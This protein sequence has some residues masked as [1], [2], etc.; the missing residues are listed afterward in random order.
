MYISLS[1]PRI[2]DE[3]VLVFFYLCLNVLL[4]TVQIF[5]VEAQPQSSRKALLQL[6]A[7]KLVDEAAIVN[8]SE[9]M[10]VP[11]LKGPDEIHLGI[12]RHIKVVHVP[13][14]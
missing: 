9:I 5:S 14:R 8:L 10:S 6:I 1:D 3:D 2:K 7:I 12:M 13:N 4:S 11:N